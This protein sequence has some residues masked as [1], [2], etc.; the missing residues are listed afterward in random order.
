M[1]SRKW[2]EADLGVDGCA[3]VAGSAHVQVKGTV[4]RC[5][6]CSWWG[7]DQFPVGAVVQ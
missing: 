3:G 4:W 7:S 6:V 1:A 5:A 2:L